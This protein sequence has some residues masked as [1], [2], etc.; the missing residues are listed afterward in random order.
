MGFSGGCLCGSVRYK[1]SSDPSFVLNCHCEDCRRSTGSVY[2]TNVL[3]DEDKVQITGEVS[4]YVHTADSGNE[5]TKRF[6]PNCGTLLFGNSSG[7]QNSVSIRAGT[8][9]QFDL[10]KPQMNVFVAKK[11][12]ST[13]INDS[14]PRSEGMP[15]DRAWK[16]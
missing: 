14:L 15:T 7:R 9:D 12:E 10:I 2:G 3:V 5:M 8:I 6:C 13:P 4:L 1:V 16:K 11:I